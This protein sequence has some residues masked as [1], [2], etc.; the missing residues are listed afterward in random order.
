VADPV[1]VRL[2]AGLVAA[3]LLLTAIAALALTRPPSPVA[4]SAPVGAVSAER[5]MVHV[6][7]IAQRPH[8]IGSEDHARVEAYLART[9]RELGLDVE[10]QRTTGVTPRYRAAGYVENVIGRLRGAG[11]SSGAVMLSAHYDSVAAGPGAGDDASGVAA[12]LEAVRALRAWPVPLRNDVVVLFTDGEETGLLGAS[13][14]MSEHALAREV[15]VAVNLEARGSSGVS[16]L[17]ETSAGNDALV[18]EAEAAIPDLAGSS[19]S[20][21]V[22]KRMPNDTDLT[23]FKAAGLA[24][25]NFAF[26]GRVE[27]YHTPSDDPAHLD[28]G[29]LQQQTDYAFGLA[30]KLGDADLDTLRPGVS[31]DS[32]FFS[33]PGRV[34]VRY[35][36]TTGVAL[37]LVACVLLALGIRRS[38]N[39]RD[40]TGPGVLLGL[41]MFVV[42]LAAAAVIGFALVRLAEALHASVLPEGNVSTS[43]GYAVAL[44]TLVLAG[45]GGLYALLRSAARRSIEDLALGGATGLV[46]LT[47]VTSLVV[48]GVAYVFLVPALCAST[49]RSRGRTSLAVSLALAIPIVAVTIPL[50]H[51]VFEGLG[52]TAPGGAMLGVLVAL[53]AGA[54]VHPLAA[55]LAPSPRGVALA[56]AL[57]GALLFGVAMAR[58]RTTDEHP[59]AS[60]L[61]YVRDATVGE[62]SPR[63]ARWA[64]SARHGDA[65]TEAF[66]GSHPTSEPLFPGWSREWL[67][68]PA[69]D[70]GPLPPL[71]PLKLDVV[72]ASDTA[73]GRG[74]TVRVSVDDGAERSLDL[75]TDADVVGSTVNGTVVPSEPPPR[76]W[77]LTFANVA[78]GL[79]LVLDVRGRGAVRMTA[80]EHLRGLPVDMPALRGKP[81]RPASSVTV[82][83][84]DQRVV[85]STFLL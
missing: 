82:H 36:H 26:V 52:V 61:W 68:G 44:V 75:E 19:L 43:G 13:A 84:G 66:V 32:V 23:V 50:M 35:S 55:V 65:W 81:A 2:V 48:P 54:I 31:A 6:S 70:E 80:T 21:E 67:V 74:I 63:R 64:S 83:D 40:A 41:V 79:V 12:I 10:V 73:V 30:R 57:T 25:L 28:L 37:A 4:A 29:S 76:P 72:A 60:R 11:P 3:V 56:V 20:Y 8:P 38:L 71:S 39:A 18:R 15:R 27:A 42:S 24:A 16:S 46:A 17:F 1:R 33:L 51:G 14:F 45:W 49:P 7:A 78:D 5:A 69:R 53:T 62:D 58:T 47:L 77:T 9:L 85:R 22:Y 34:F 59:K